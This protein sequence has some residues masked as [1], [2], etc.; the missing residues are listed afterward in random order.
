MPSW[1]FRCACTPGLQEAG[2]QSHVS[3]N[4]HEWSSSFLSQPARPPLKQLLA[5]RVQGAE[6]PLSTY[7]TNLPVGV[8]GIPMFFSR[9]AIA[10]I[11][12]PPVSE[13]VKK[14]CKW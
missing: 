12:Y 8:P 3:F 10:A 14:R 7:I 6:S 11:E 9:E 1:R 5:H 4:T 13:Q 2:Q